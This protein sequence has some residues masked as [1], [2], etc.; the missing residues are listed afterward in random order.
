MP[1]TPREAPADFELDPGGG[2]MY[3]GER[4][5]LVHETYG[6]NPRLL[7][8]SMTEQAEAVPPSIPRIPG[9]IDGHEQN[10]LAAVRGEAEASCPFSYASDLT[11]V[12]N[13]GIVAMHTTGPIE[14]DAVN[15]RIP[16]TPE[17][18]RFLTR[19]YRTGWELPTI[20]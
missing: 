19:T 16:G 12:M 4:G 5:T 6:L 2:V 1:P 9:G 20:R 7:P 8:A 10:F 11:E 15:M 17:V 18:E 14:Y 13:L 3:V